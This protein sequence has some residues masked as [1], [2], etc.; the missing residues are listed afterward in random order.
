M[1]CSKCILKHTEMKHEVIQISPKV[2]EMKKL[3]E[4]GKE[5]CH[6]TN[7]KAGYQILNGTQGSCG[8]KVINGRAIHMLSYDRCPGA[9][10]PPCM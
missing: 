10:T 7:M 4:F 6:G 1:F 8:L 5:W 3:I 9:G 2:E